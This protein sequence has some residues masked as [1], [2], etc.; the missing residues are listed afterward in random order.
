LVS[1]VS[2]AVA[3]AK[4]LVA[5]AF[6]RTSSGSY[7]RGGCWVDVVVDAVSSVSGAATFTKSP[8]APAFP[9]RAGAHNGGGRYWV[10]VAVLELLGW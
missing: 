2:C 10:D 4:L 8:A 1:S 6:P 5:P 3:F 9:V 7:G